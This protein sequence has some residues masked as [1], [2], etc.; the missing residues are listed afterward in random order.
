[1]PHEKSRQFSAVFNNALLLLNTLKAINIFF[2]LYIILKLF[3]FTQNNQEL[4]LWIIML[5]KLAINLPFSSKV[6]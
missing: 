2:Y 4:K 5:Y 3:C 6:L 1:M